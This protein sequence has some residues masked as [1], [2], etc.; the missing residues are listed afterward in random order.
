LHDHEESHMSDP[1][2]LHQQLDPADYA[3]LQDTARQQ[4][5]Q[6]RAEA[7]A[8]TVRWAARAL[9]GAGRRL[10]G[11]DVAA[12]PAVLGRALARAAARWRERAL[13]RLRGQARLRQL[14]RGAA[15]TV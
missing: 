1:R 4:A 12:G 7:I 9:A 3:S 10:A 11:T 6:L 14:R 2:P 8:A 13:R 15:Q 5:V